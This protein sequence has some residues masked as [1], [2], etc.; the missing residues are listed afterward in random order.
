M[1]RRTFGWTGES[2]PLIGQ[3]TWKMELDDSSAA[4][5]ALQRGFE[6]G[7][8]HLDTAELYGS[9]EVETLVSRAIAGRRDQLFLASKVMPS[10]AT[11]EGTLRACERSLTRLKTDRLDLYLL[12]W[13]GSHPLE[14]TI[15]AFEKL[16]TE[17]KIRFWGV[18]NFDVDELDEAVAIAGERRIACNQV[19]YHL[20]AR[21]IEPRVL[22][23]CE[24]H[25]V[26]LVGYSPFGSGDFPSAKSAGGRV[27]AAIA[28]AHHV[29]PYQIAL[30]YLVR[31]APLF[32]IPKSANA[33]HA[34]SNARAGELT[35]SAEALRQ[36]DEV[37]PIRSDRLDV[38]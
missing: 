18:S 30:A 11:Y 21:N 34:E 35:L 13:P 32:T 12:H 36:L 4:I 3:G 20:G 14:D 25:E 33:E 9:G 22:P 24:E 5:A 7:M 16:V 26:A 17:G 27:L 8:T 31:R 10:N 38:I 1:K 37:F 2:V 15:R 23:W 19:L 28:K 29:T 6:V